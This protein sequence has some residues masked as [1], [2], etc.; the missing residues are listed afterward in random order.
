MMYVYIYQSLAKLKNDKNRIRKI[1]L[2]ETGLICAY[3]NELKNN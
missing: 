2:P 3:G 1:L